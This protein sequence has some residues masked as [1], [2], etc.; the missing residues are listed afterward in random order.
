MPASRSARSVLDWTAEAWNPPG[1]NDMSTTR[2]SPQHGR[3]ERDKSMS[4]QVRAVAQ[5]RG[6]M[7]DSEWARRFS[8]PRR[9]ES[10]RDGDRI[11]NSRADRRADARSFERSLGF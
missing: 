7:P 3:A 2:S 4:A 9:G 10:W 8:D 1:V 6:R 5:A 11:R